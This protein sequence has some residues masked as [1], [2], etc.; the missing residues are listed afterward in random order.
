LQPAAGLRRSVAVRR[1]AGALLPF[2]EHR[3]LSEF[4]CR[5]LSGFCLAGAGALYQIRHDREVFFRIGVGHRTR[6]DRCT[7]K[8]PPGTDLPLACG[9]PPCSCLDHGSSTGLPT[10]PEGVQRNRT[11]G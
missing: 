9:R 6:L 7:P 1:R 3:I 5:S 2:A 11:F 8:Q 10:S 4:L